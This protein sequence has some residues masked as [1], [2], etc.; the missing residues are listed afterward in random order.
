MSYAF[1]Q[2]KYNI[3]F[4]EKEKEFIKEHPI[5]EFGYEPRWEPYE[6]YE[7]GEY[8]GIVG[9]YVK[10]IERETDIQLKPI[11]NLT[12]GETVDGLQS[13]KIKM[14]PC[15]AITPKRREFLEFTSVYINDPMVIVVRKDY[16][17]YIGGLDDLDGKTVALPVNY[18]TSELL[19][20]NH[21][22]IKQV[23]KPNIQECLE[24]LSFEEVDAFID[25]LAVVSYY[26]NNKGFSNLKISAP[27][28]YKSNGIALATTKDF[29]IFR[30]IAQKVLDTITVAE[31][32]E[33]RQKWI[34]SDYGTGFFNR[35]MWKWGIAYGLFLISI[36]IFFYL[37][38]KSLRKQIKL[39]KLI[40]ERLRISIEEIKKQDNEKKILLQ[41]IHHRV[42][43]NL[44]IVSSMMRLQ[45]NVTKDR[46]SVKTLNEAIERIKTIAL[47]H[48]KIYKSPGVGSVSINEYLKELINDIL[49]NYSLTNKVKV[50]IKVSN[51]ELSIDNVVPLGLIINELVT[52]SLKYAFEDL[53][54]PK[55]SIVFTNKGSKSTGS[56]LIYTD[57]GTWIENPNSDHFGTSLI[58]IFTEQL[59]GD[60]QLFKEDGETRYVFVFNA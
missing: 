18:Y 5:I 42:K 7:N 13:G 26:M 15:C 55:I 32:S 2:K 30:D 20:E 3:N 11:P 23:I 44:Q 27:T 1:S 22:G 36:I 43:N 10:I 6:M 52:N 17:H 8:K 34:S 40:E 51:I 25:N 24:A 47:V 46:K 21:Q 45:S 50:D 12:W 31:Q 38:N 57:N 37:W 59:E 53:K 14:V 39:R 58:G 19:A 9:E 33:I 56:Q 28:P 16:P 54:K 41:E 35:R 48:D 4:N 49:S 29:V 60:Y